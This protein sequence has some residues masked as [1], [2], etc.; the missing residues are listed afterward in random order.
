MANNLLSGLPERHYRTGEGIFSVCSA[1]GPTLETAAALAAQADTPLLVE[2]TSNQVDQFGGYTG[3]TPPRFREWLL[4]LVE[5][6]GLP[7]DRLILGGDHL[8]PNPWRKEP[9][10]AAMD[11]ARELIRQ[12]AGSGFG[13]L[14]L[15][16]SMALGGDPGPAP[17]GEVVARRAAELCR[18][19]EEAA[20]AGGRTPPVYVIGTE[21]PIPGGV[22]HELDAS[23]APTSVADARETLDIHRSVFAKAGLQD[24]WTRVIALVVQPGVEFGNYTVVDYD[25]KKAAELSRFIAGVGNLVFEA[26]STDYQTA[27]GLAEMVEDHFAVMK[28][29]PHLTFA[30]REALF[31]LEAIAAELGL[32]PKLRRVMEAEML[33]SPG[34]WRGHYHG[35]EEAEKLAR[36]FSFSDR[37]R[38]YW[39]NENIR[40][41]AEDLIR[42]LAA[43]EI[44]YSLLSQYLPWQYEE[45]RAGRL[46]NRPEA[47]LKSGV[48]RVLGM[49]AA[50]ARMRRISTVLP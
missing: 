46:A 50:A 28:V 3:L 22:A 12:F 20:R 29:G 37:A 41:A 45:I 8:G 48:G 27:R 10:E 31:G 13:K 15:D 36:A 5:K 14:H 49:F 11:K 33:A 7:K 1:H 39:P 42:D 40:A 19:A 30:Y 25:R 44:P 6:A 38:Y 18:V 24:A 32:A 9:A 35:G 2:A 47:L 43:V 21:V 26:H 4:G 23:L 16:C 34:Y 17:A